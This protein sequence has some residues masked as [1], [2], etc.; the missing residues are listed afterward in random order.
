MEG[1][2]TEENI[3]TIMEAVFL[4]KSDKTTTL[5]TWFNQLG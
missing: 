4:G 3:S 5:A 1:A 2:E